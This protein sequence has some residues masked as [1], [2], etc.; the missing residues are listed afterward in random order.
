MP[1][2]RHVLR[3]CGALALISGCPA[4]LGT[5]SGAGDDSGT[6]SSSSDAPPGNDDSGHTPARLA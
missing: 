3:I 6:S 2:D 4:E 5:A 1:I